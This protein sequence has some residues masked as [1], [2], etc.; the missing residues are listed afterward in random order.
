MRISP[1]GGDGD[2]FALRGDL[3]CPR[4]QSRQSAAGGRR[5]K[6][7][8]VFLCRRA[9]DPLFFYRGATKWRGYIHPARVKDRTPFLAPPA[10]APCYLNRCLLLQERSRLVFSH[11]GAVRWSLRLRGLF[12]ICKTT[13]N[14][15]LLQVRTLWRLRRPQAYSG[16]EVFRLPP[17]PRGVHPIGGP[18]PPDWSFQGDGFPKGRGKSKSPF[19]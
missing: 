10:A 4:R 3:L 14:T 9:P 7:H 18:K 1:A 16:E 8:S 5:L 6:K 19:P 11:R 13:V 12:P 17:T 2:G 15:H